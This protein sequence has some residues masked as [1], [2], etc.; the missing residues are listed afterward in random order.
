MSLRK[1]AHASPPKRDGARSAR[2]PGRRPDGDALLFL[3]HTNKPR[4]LHHFDRLK[5]ETAGLLDCFLCVD[6]EALGL[7]YSDFPPNLPVRRTD[8]ET[9]M[10]HRHRHMAANEDGG[11]FNF[12]DLL[13]IPVAAQLARIGYRRIWVV[14]YDVDFA[15]PWSDFFSKLLNSKA[16]LLATTLRRRSSSSAWTYWKRFGCP[17]TVRPEH[18][19]RSFLPILRLSARMLEAYLEALQDEAWRGHYEALLPTIALHNGLVVEDIGGSGDHAPPSRRGR[20]Y[21]NTADDR[22][23]GPG[24]L[25]Y[26][27]AVS[28]SYFGEEPSRFR[29]A[30]MLYHPVKVAEEPPAAV[31]LR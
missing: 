19:H 27:P 1:P 18:Q 2:Q 21:A 25:I 6:T 9:L 15:G 30:G 12:I 23:L 8:A 20:Y 24:T 28:Q 7:S 13:F 31:V 3:T 5:A 26:R 4:V 29:H 14:E 11:Y 22:F 17:P 16:D 10:P